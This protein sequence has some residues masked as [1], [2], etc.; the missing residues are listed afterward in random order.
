MQTLLHYRTKQLSSTIIYNISVVFLRFGVVPVDV[1]TTREAAEEVL[2]T[3]DLETC[4]RPKLAATKL[5]SCNYKGH[6]L[7]SVR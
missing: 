2:K 3:H 6:W 7:C 1:F 4:T 5:F